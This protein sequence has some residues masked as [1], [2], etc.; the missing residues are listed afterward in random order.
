MSEQPDTVKQ[1][2]SPLPVPHTLYTDLADHAKSEITWVRSAYKFAASL[3]AVVFAVGIAFTY[4][5]SSDFK[6]NARQ[7]MERQNQQMIDRL[8]ATEAQMQAKLDEKVA[9]LSRLVEERIDKEFR[10]ENI[11]ALVENKAQSRIDEIAD[12]LIRDH[13]AKSIAPQI[14][15]AHDQLQAVKAKMEKADRTISELKASSEF[16]TTVIAA[17]NDSR[18]A[19]DRLREWSQDASFPRRVEAKQAWVKILDA[20]ASPIVI[21]GYTVPWREG[22][23]PSEL[24]LEN[25]K[26][27]YTSAPA[28]IRLGLVEYIWGRQDFPKHQRMAFLAH[29]LE[30]DESLHVVENAARQFMGESKQNLKPLAVEQQLEWWKKNRDKIESNQPKN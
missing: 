18:P 17:Q 4:K 27:S 5:S 11:H 30:T 15:N 28:L 3:V 21:S 6:A 25:L 23:D 22:V 7:D 19:F 20:H 14:K 8:T 26:A 29:V 12:L 9:R 10:T 2:E 13:V 16:T 24:S 1:P